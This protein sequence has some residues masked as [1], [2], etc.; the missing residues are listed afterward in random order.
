MTQSY[1]DNDKYILRRM[2]ESD[3]T[4]VLEMMRVFYSS[5]AVSTDASDDI[6]NKDITECVSESPFVEGFVFVKKDTAKISG[7]AMLA[8]SFSTEFG[9]RCVWIED[10]YLKE[11]ARGEGLASQFLDFVQRAFP[12]DLQRLDSESYNE[13]ALDIYYRKGFSLLPYIELVRN[14]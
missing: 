5:D 14:M 8:H 10:L 13:H 3:R 2:A 4:P 7:Y 1:I 11:E 6:F 12:D 9:R